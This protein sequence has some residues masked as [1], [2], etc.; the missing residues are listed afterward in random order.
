MQE[1]ARVI[2]ERIMQ[3]WCLLTEDIWCN[4]ADDSLSSW[5]LLR[6]LPHV[7]QIF[8]LLYNMYTS[9]YDLKIIWF[10]MLGAH[11]SLVVS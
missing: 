2:S 1:A 4:L 11:L 3:E 8:N 7:F 10:G 5:R 9:F 6:K